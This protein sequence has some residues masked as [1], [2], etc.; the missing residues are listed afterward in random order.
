MRFSTVSLFALP[1]LAAAAQ[2]ESPVEQILEQAKVQ[3]QYWY[4]KISAYVPNIPNP[5]LE[6][7]VDA[8]A[9]AAGGKTLTVLTLNSWEQKIRSSVTPTSSGPEEWWVLVTGGN[10]TCFGQ[11]TATETAFNETALLF[12]ADPAAPHLAYLNCDD[13]PVLCNSW[14]AGPPNLWIL[15]VAAPPAPVD[16]HIYPL[17]TTT[18]TVGTF[19]D[20]LG[21]QEWKA[22][23]LYEGY[24]HPFDGPIAQYGLSQPLGYVLWVF[25]IVPSWLFMI[26]ISFLSRTFLGGRGAGG[27]AARRPAE[28]AA[29]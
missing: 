6:H 3:A 25:A 11:C 13:Q 14:G 19:T 5:N 22:K 7:P 15:E 24:F 23:P 2:Q 18:T 21:S 10:K 27:A 20:L 4:E 17:N 29:Q 1:L 28:A 16:I 8:A 12:A 9:S 26:S